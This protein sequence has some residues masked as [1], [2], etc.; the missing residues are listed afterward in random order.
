MSTYAKALIALL[1]AAA[2]AAQ[3]ALSDGVVTASEWVSIAIAALGALAVYAVP[4]TPPPP[5]EI[6]GKHELR[7]DT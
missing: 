1:T 3:T 6:P 5:P 4:N 2:I 7:E